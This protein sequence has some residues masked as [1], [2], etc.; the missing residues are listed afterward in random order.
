MIIFVTWLAKRV[1]TLSIHGIFIYAGY[2][3]QLMNSV[4]K[5]PS[6]TTLTHLQAHKSLDAL[7]NSSVS[8]TFDVEYDG[9]RG[10]LA[11]S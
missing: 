5:R 9:F 7:L 2:F 3:W 8:M 11:D 10:L 1:D 4:G 6:V